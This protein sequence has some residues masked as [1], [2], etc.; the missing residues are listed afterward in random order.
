MSGEIKEITANR[1]RFLDL[2][3]LADPEEAVV[4]AYLDKG[5]LFVLYEQGQPY[6]VILLLPHDPQTI[7]IKNIAIREDAQGQGYGKQLISH[8]K[9]FGKTQGYTRLIVGTCNSSFNEL[10]F[11]QKAGFRF[12]DII[13][14]FFTDNYKEPI[15][16]NGIQCRDMLM[17]EQDL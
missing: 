2:L 11:Y 5:H 14:D 13:R 8:A 4:L 10:A 1:E 9:A 6:G 12:Y 7:E 17:L 3:L 16:E 15:F